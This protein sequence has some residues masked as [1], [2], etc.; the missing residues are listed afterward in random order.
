M[1]IYLAAACA[2]PSGRPSAMLRGKDC[3]V[4][5]RI[6]HTHPPIRECV[7][8][9]IICNLAMERS[10]PLALPPSTRSFYHSSPRSPTLQSQSRQ[11]RV[12]G[13]HDCHLHHFC[14]CQH[15][16]RAETCVFRW[17]LRM[18]ANKKQNHF[19]QQCASPSPLRSHP[20]AR[21]SLMKKKPVR[22]IVANTRHLF[23]R[24]KRAKVQNVRQFLKGI[25]TWI[26][27]RVECP[28]Q[29]SNLR[30]RIGTRRIVC[31]LCPP[32]VLT[33]CHPLSQLPLQRT[34]LRCH[35]EDQR[36]SIEG[37]HEPGSCI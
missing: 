9:S 11:A 5:T 10:H 27:A 21:A 18:H 24:R 16:C 35:V 33:C 8:A 37:S 29:S 3:L 32:C 14:N 34:K 15:Q 36:V 28:E 4:R 23:C 2:T 30:G 7:A 17:S 22:S 13:D 25:P 20:L 31:M 6:S 26:D 19:E 1:R 12:G